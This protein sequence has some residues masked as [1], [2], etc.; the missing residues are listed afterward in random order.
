MS[1]LLCGDVHQP[2]SVFC[3]FFS[4]TQI[5]MMEQHKSTQG[6]RFVGLQLATSHRP[7]TQPNAARRPAP[8]PTKPS[9]QR[10]PFGHDPLSSTIGSIEPFTTYRSLVS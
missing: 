2:A 10:F 8:S 9:R 6:F 3:F 4:T 5:A 7:F 1:L